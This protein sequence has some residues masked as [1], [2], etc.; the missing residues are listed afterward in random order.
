MTTPTTKLKD[1]KI[2][3][4]YKTFKTISRNAFSLHTK[5]FIRVI[6]KPKTNVESFQSIATKIFFKSQ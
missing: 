6:I 3:S 2:S 4:L 5:I 1:I